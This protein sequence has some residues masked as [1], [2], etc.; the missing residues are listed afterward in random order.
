MRAVVVMEYGGKAEIVELPKPE[1][2]PGKILI[3]IAAAGMNPMDRTIAGGVW[4]SVMAATFPMILGFDFAGVIGDIDEEATRFGVGESIMGQLLLPPVGAFGTYAEYVAV[5]EQA[6]LT[7]IPSG[8]DPTVAAAAPTAGMSGLA[9]VDSLSP[10]DGK[11]VLIVGAAGGV[12][13]FVTQLAA[14]AGA[15][16]I[17][18][19]RQENVARMRSYGVS[20]IIDIE[21]PLAEVVARSHP[22]GIDALIDVVNDADDFAALA[23][24]VRN[25]GT[26]LT[27]RYV[28]DVDALA[29]S[30]VTATNFQ[31]PASSELLER[32]AEVLTAKTIVPPPIKLISLADAP[33]A[34]DG[35]GEPL[36]DGKTVIVI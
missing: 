24:L 11:T 34:F 26:A 28:A 32:L 21:A 1:V 30:G 3:K 13:S 6:T 14:N 4:K 18:N 25:G 15:N 27:S 29:A 33:S 19:V 5:S 35:K 9:I 20:E 36:F 22:D 17:A 8:V 10:L 7:R 31:L 23:A 16:V 2:G 12:G